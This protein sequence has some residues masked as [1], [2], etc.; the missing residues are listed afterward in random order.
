M[1]ANKPLL[2]DTNSGFDGEPWAA[3][4]GQPADARRDDRRNQKP[5][6]EGPGGDAAIPP[7]FGKD[8]REQQRESCARVDADRHRHKRHSDKDPAIEERQPDPAHR[9]LLRGAGD[10]RSSRDQI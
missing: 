9:N 10:V 7:E 5:E 8:W 4:V 6:R 2:I 1:P 3:A